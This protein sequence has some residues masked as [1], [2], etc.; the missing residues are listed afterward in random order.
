M[1]TLFG[2]SAAA[3]GVAVVKTSAGAGLGESCGT[4]G[5][6]PIAKGVLVNE[7]V[8]FAGSAACVCSDDAPEAG[9]ETDP[10]GF[11]NAPNVKGEGTV[12]GTVAGFSTSF[13]IVRGSPVAGVDVANAD[14]GRDGALNGDGFVS[15]AFGVGSR[16]SAGFAGSAPGTV[17]KSGVVTAAGLANTEELAKKFGI[18]VGA[19][20]GTGVGVSG[21]SFTASGVGGMS[22][23]LGRA[24]TGVGGI[25][26]GVAFTVS[27]VGCAGTAGLVRENGSEVT[28][29]SFARVKSCVTVVYKV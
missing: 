15:S 28:G 26:C 9:A 21:K 20:L 10:T 7:A 24:G 11:V 29:G 4:E 18:P 8:C 23:I 5:G 25:S 6:A 22:A 14:T 13:G 2:A 27:A 19:A 16:T 1:N 12:G 17:R 3:V